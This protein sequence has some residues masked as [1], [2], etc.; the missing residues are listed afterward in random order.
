VNP[1]VYHIVSGQAFFSGVVLIIL[2]ALLSLREN[3]M[4]RRV[5]VLSVLL[6]MILIAVSSTPL[7]W[8]FYSIAGVVTL[9]WVCSGF[10]KKWRRGAAY[11]VM[12]VWLV[13]LMLEV[14]Y[15]LTPGVEPDASRS[16]TVIGDSVTAGLG[17]EDTE[18][19]PRILQ[20]KHGIAVQ[21][22]SHVGDTVASAR[23]RV[24]ATEIK[25]PL[26][27]LEIGGNDILGS[28]TAAQFETK[29]DALLSELAAPSRQLVMLELPLPPFYHAYGRIQRDLARKHNVALVPKRVFLSIIAGGD[30]TL[31]SIHLSQAGHLDMTEVVWGIIGSAYSSD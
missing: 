20:R 1:I 31:D 22:L 19:W 24:A 7:P 28:T 12:G 30:A 23:K 17:D 16:L 13:A 11:A 9:V 10:M 25:S 26:V 4:A 18:T 5:M 15:H 8:W 2:A 27:L 29:L 6:G 21:D 3:R 14:P